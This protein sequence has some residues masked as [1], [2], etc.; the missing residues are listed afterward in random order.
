MSPSCYM[1]SFSFN[2]SNF[3]ENLANFLI[4]ECLEMLGSADYTVFRVSGP[5]ERVSQR[6]SYDHKRYLPG[7]LHIPTWNK[8]SVPI[9]VPIHSLRHAIIS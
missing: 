9:V 3:E 2:F 1:T 4:V 7:G 6:T 8:W 5:L